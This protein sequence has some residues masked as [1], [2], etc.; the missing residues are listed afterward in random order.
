MLIV[1]LAII[2]FSYK[3]IQLRGFHVTQVYSYHTMFQV[4]LSSLYMWMPKHMYNIKCLVQL[5]RLQMVLHRLATYIFLSFW[6]KWQ[7]KLTVLWLHA[8]IVMHHRIK[9]SCA[10]QMLSGF[11]DVYFKM[12]SFWT[13]LHVSAQFNRK[14]QNNNTYWC[15]THL[16]N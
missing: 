12:L 13:L 7:A 5:K 14:I 16:I 6:R 2:A 3:M 11:S 15:Q 8:N 9:M 4:D 10:G 1:L